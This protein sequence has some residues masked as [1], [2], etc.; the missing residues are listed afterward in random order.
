[1]PDT[2]WRRDDANRIVIVPRRPLAAIL[3][4]LPFL[5]IGL[6]FTY[7]LLGAIYDGARYGG[8]HGLLGALP[9]ALLL[10]V[11]AALFGGPGVV[12]VFGSKRTTIDALAGTVLDVRDFVVGQRAREFGRGEF[13]RVDVTY[14]SLR[15]SVRDDPTRHSA[16]RF[17]YAVAL[18]RPRGERLLLALE[19]ERADAQALAREVGGLVAL[20]V[21][22]VSDVAGQR[23]SSRSSSSRSSRSGPSPITPA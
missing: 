3:F 22:D 11:A 17:V 14:E 12:L 15:E 1:M 4:G 7:Q 2:K 23:V 6:Y 16:P 10:I 20:P 9:G 18:G 21:N 8:M 19:Q 5:G 13:A